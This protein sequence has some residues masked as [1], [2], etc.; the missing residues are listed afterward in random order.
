MTIHP[1]GFYFDSAYQSPVITVTD[2]AMW[3][4][5]PTSQVNDGKSACQESVS[6]S[7]NTYEL[8]HWRPTEARN[9]SKGTDFSKE[10]AN[11]WQTEFKNLTVFSPI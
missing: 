6:S 10:M 11:Q 5:L 8:S 1:N 3:P 2:E 9:L 4:V 7:V